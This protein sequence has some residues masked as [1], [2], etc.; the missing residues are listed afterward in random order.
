MGEL[1]LSIKQNLFYNIFGSNPTSPGSSSGSTLASRVS[2]GRAFG[3]GRG[4]AV[5]A[6]LVE[7]STNV[8]V[9]KLPWHEVKNVGENSSV[10]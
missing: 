7:H 4:A 6:K 3:A 8:W 9:S 10:F 1:I 2:S 5:A